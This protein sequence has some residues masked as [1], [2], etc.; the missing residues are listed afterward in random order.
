MARADGAAAA[1][2]ASLVLLAS[3]WG[4][5]ISRSAGV[6]AVACALIAGVRAVLT[7]REV[8]DLPEACRLARTDE[9]TGLAN[10]RAL[11][12]RCD[13]ALADPAAHPV[14]LLRLDLDGFK[15]VNDTFGHQA[16]DQLLVHVASPAR[17]DAA[18]RRPA[19]PPR[20]RRV[21]GAAAREA[22]RCPGTPRAA[23]V[24]HDGRAHRAPPDDR[25]A[26][27]R[28]ILLLLRRRGVGVSIDDYGTGYSSLSYLRHLPA[29]ELKLD[30]TLSLDVTTSGRAASIVWHTVALAHD[31]G[32]RVVAE[33]IQDVGTT[34]ALHA[35]GCDTGQ[36]YHLAVPMPVDEFVAWLRAHRAGSSATGL[37]VP[38]SRPAVSGARPRAAGG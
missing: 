31:L 29:D 34:R 33:G 24:G 27:A 8:R 17:S 22:G 10:R 7:L 36:G 13:R 5:A 35:L 18:T 9:L 6:F 20:R 2:T 38:A 23:A 16:G 21:R 3:G 30:R 11:S 1:F 14:A 37:A 25:A 12:E 4:D 15:H 19:G 32:L 28:D 26:R